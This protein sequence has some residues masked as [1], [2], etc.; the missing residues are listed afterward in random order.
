MESIAYLGLE[1]KQRELESRLLIA[2]R[3]LKAGVVVFFGQQWSL[4]SNADALPPGVVLFKTVN[5]I[6]AKP[7][8]DF[9]SKG[10]IVASTDEEVFGLY[11][12]GM[13]SRGL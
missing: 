9:R 3:L 4:F 5:G 13:F 7:M 2:A 1:I 8:A 11:G 10:H 12:R 6:Q